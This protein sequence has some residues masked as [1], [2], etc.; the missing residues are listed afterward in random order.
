MLN[1]HDI[2]QR[3]EHCVFL[4]SSHLHHCTRNNVMSLDYCHM[5]RDEEVVVDFDKTTFVSLKVLCKG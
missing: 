5:I 3:N 2:K 4:A 1:S